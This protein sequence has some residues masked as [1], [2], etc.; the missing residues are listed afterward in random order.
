MAGVSIE[1]V[2]L[3][4]IA[5]IFGFYNGLVS[6]SSLVAII[7]ST[8]AMQPRSALWMAAIGVGIGPLL[9]GVAVATTIGRDVVRID[10][11]SSAIV[12]AAILAAIAWNIFTLTFGIPS[13]SSHALVGGI[14][15]AVWAGIGL[16][17]I[18]VSGLLTVV[19]A[20]LLSPLLGIITGMLMLNVT[21]WATKNA[22]PRINSWFRRGEILSGAALALAHGTNDA[23]K[24]MGVI[25]LGLV[26]TGEIKTFAVPTWVILASA[27]VMAAGTL[28]G[29]WSLIRTLG[30][31]F[32]RIR[33]VHGFSAQM[34]SSMVILVAALLG[35]P[36]S[37]THVVSTSIVGAGAADRVQMVRWGVLS[38]IVLSWVLT[39][40]ATA[41]ISAL[42][43]A[44]ITLVT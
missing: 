2:G 14:I 4:F 19:L 28:L 29:G 31:K 38:N 40:P 6:A 21:Y 9:F 1:T 44:C 15:G 10:L 30:N 5:L 41:I 42:I 25:V 39:I 8:R 3:V 36:A 12:Y 37:T 32:Y 26:V 16:E 35:G 23:Q 34:G 18:Q 13:S 20:L 24:T 7:I 22:T 43:Y 11:V 27:S 33:P 17:A